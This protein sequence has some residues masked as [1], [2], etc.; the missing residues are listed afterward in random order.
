MGGGETALL[1]HN[2]SSP[3]IIICHN[4]RGARKIR[5]KKVTIEPAMY[6]YNFCGGES[7]AVSEPLVPPP[8]HHHSTIH[9]HISK[10][11]HLGVGQSVERLV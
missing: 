8:A 1:C 10:D 7:K 3:L 5:V 9:R 4:H 2:Q 6:Q 11:A